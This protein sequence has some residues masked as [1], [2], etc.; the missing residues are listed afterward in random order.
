[1]Q[2]LIHEEGHVIIPVHRNYLDGKSDK[3]HDIGHMPLGPLGG[4]EWPEFAWLE[5]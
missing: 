1:M 2:K 4:N 3:V 5:D